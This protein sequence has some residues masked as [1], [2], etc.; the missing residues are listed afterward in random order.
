MSKD[1]TII[2]AVHIILSYCHE[3]EISIGSRAYVWSKTT[4]WGRKIKYDTPDALAA[5]IISGEY[6]PV[7]FKELEA[8]Q[9]FY[10]DT[11]FE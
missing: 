10:F 4:T 3:H 7:S 9:R 1:K 2:S 5:F 6:E 11:I 8:L